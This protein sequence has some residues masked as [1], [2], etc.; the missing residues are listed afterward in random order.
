MALAKKKVLIQSNSHISLYNGLLMSGCQ[1]RIIS[2]EYEKTHDIFMP[3]TV[4]QIKKALED[5]PDIKA[6]YLTS[7]SYEGLCCDYRAIKDLIGDRY[8]IVDE[9]HG[10]H[11]YFS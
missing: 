2:T 1:I 3:A 4:A 9:A 7:P 5:E 6:V 11:H 10:A 8:L